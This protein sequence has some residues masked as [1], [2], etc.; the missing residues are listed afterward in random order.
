MSSFKIEGTIG[1]CILVD[2]GARIISGSEEGKD[3]LGSFKS[4]TGPA[5]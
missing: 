2:G 1:T 5:N 4:L 3:V